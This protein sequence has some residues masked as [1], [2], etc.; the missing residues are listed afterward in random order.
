[1]LTGWVRPAVAIST[2]G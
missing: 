1:M 2:L